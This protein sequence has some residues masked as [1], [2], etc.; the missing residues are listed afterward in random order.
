[1]KFFYVHTDSG[2]ND[3]GCEVGSA[4]GS[5]KLFLHEYG[6]EIAQ[7]CEGEVAISPFA[8]DIPMSS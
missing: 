3:R 6:S 1:M 7:I 2:A 5:R 8:V 4:K